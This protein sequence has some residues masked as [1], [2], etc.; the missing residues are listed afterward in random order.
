MQRLRDAIGSPLGLAICTDA[1]QAV[2]AGVKEVFSSAEH[3]ECMLHLVTNFK[4]R[5]TGKVFEDHLWAAAYSW[6][7]Y[8]FEKNWSAM[9][10]ANP[11]AMDY[12]RKHHSK[13][14][15]RSQ[16]WTHCK[17][18]YV[19]NNLAECFN[20]WVKKYKG[21]NLDDLMDLIRQLIMDKWDIRR[22]ISEKMGGVIL[23]HIIKDLRERSRNLD[24]DV[25][26]SGNTL[27]EVSVK[28]SNG[29]KCV[30]NLE[31]RTCS[32]RKWQVSGIPCKHAI[33]FIT[34][35]GEP[36][37]KYVDMFYSVDKFKAAYEALIPALPDKSQW[38]QSDHNFFIH[39]P[40]LKPTAGRRQNERFKG[41]TEGST[42]KRKGS[43]Q[44]KVCKNYGHRWYKCKDGDPDDIAAMLTEK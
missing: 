3:R 44:C 4:K 17:V 19:T 28:G 40:F 9:D 25:Q 6:S 41:C 23:P 2:M 1:G 35:L 32:C 29:Y 26:R 22:D 15:T 42:T 38:A 10:E 8:I 18:D 7:P 16:F 27:A 37:E 12:I 30:V 11:E 43:H 5:Y 34:Y 14:W 39:P 31:E 20:N 24:M 13:I 36:L 33:A 21:L